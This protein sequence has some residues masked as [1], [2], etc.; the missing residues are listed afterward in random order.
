MRLSR[1]TNAEIKHLQFEYISEEEKNEIEKEIKKKGIQFLSSESKTI[2][3]WLSD[4]GIKKYYSQL[5]LRPLGVQDEKNP[6]I[7]HFEC[8]DSQIIYYFI[9]FGSA[10]K[11]I[12][13]S[14]LATVFGTIYKEAYYSYK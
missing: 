12:A 13:P 10:A 6:H 7:F 4:E 8:T 14:S 3:V 2:S 1:I 9:S 11:I 5:H